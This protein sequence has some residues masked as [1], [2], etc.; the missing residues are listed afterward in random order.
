VYSF[1]CASLLS[2]GFLVSSHLPEQQLGV[3]TDRI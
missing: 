3:T 2:F 1:L